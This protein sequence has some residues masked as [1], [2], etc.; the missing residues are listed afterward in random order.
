[1]VVG[2]AV[3]QKFEEFGAPVPRLRCGRAG[4]L[5]VEIH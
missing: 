2:E 4:K 5:T 3:Y 1:M